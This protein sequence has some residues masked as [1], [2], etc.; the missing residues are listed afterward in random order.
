MPFLTVGIGNARPGRCLLLRTVRQTEVG[1]GS[2]ISLAIFWAQG[3]TLLHSISELLQAVV[4]PKM[5]TYVCVIYSVTA[6][7][8]S[9]ANALYDP[10]KSRQPC[11]HQIGFGA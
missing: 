9:C 6:L 5:D 4:R 8:C 11:I 1:F 7:L 3:R 10:R 2:A